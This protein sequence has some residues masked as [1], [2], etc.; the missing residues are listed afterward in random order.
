MKKKFVLGMLTFVA[1][2]PNVFALNNNVVG[3][4]A[5]F[6]EGTVSVEIEKGNESRGVLSNSLYEADALT[7]NNA[8]TFTGI[9]YF[10]EEGIKYY[11]D[12]Y[13]NDTKTYN[14]K[15][16]RNPDPTGADLILREVTWGNNWSGEGVMIYAVNYNGT[17]EDKLIAYAYNK[18]AYTWATKNN[19]ELPQVEGADVTFETVE[20]NSDLYDTLV[21]FP[22]DF[23]YCTAIKVV[24]ITEDLKY[25]GGDGQNARDGYDLDAVYGYKILYAPVGDITYKNE[26]AIAVGETNIN[27][28]DSWQKSVMKVKVSDLLENDKV[29]DIIAGQHYKIGTGRIYLEDEIVKVD[30]KFYSYYDILGIDT[31]KVGIYRDLSSMMK[32]GKLLGN[33]QLTKNE[34]VS[35][36]DEYAYIRLHFDVSIPEYVYESIETIEE[37]PAVC[38]VVE[39]EKEDNNNDLEEDK[40][41]IKKPCNK[42]ESHKKPDKVTND[43]HENKQ[44]KKPCNKVIKKVNQV[45]KDCHK[46]ITKCTKKVYKTCHKVKLNFCKMFSR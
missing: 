38:E 5:T 41:E 26:T 35:L 1:M 42:D 40:E 9:G 14:S 7:T 28:S 12:K 45:K 13:E 43:K 3:S 34:N 24:D 36:D 33:G 6:N 44:D 31:V 17:G 37:L 18:M 46:A 16:V 20:G 39:E 32:N 15:L 11:F 22:N 8:K 19:V 25:L 4:W 10:G 21:N 2:T 27:C 29:F 23:E 30:Y